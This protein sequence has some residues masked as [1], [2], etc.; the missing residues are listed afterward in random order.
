MTVTAGMARQVRLS[1]ERAPRMM[2]SMNASLWTLSA[3][4]TSE[5]ITGLM[6]WTNHSRTLRRQ[7]VPPCLILQYLSHQIASPG[8]GMLFRAT[9]SQQVLS[10]GDMRVHTLDSLL[11]V[12]AAA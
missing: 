2:C 7:Q 9:S 6:T 5:L 1:G 12:P 3:A 11:Q 8:C 4:H 10:G